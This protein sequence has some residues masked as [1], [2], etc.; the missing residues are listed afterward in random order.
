VKVNEAPLPDGERPGRRTAAEITTLRSKKVNELMAVLR[1]K[2]P[3][4]PWLR[5]VTDDELWGMVR[6]MWDKPYAQANRRWLR[7]LDNE[8][9]RRGDG[10]KPGRIAI[11]RLKNQW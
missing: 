9:E 6:R 10:R 2:R 3:I 4:E 8:W 7:A 11:R 1:E 5:S